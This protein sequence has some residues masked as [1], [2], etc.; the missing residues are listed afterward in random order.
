MFKPINITASAKSINES[1][2]SDIIFDQELQY[3]CNQLYQEAVFSGA[4]ETVKPIED[5][6]A[7]I[8]QQ[9]ETEIERHKA[10]VKEKSSSKLFDP[11]AF[12]KNL[13]FKQ[14]EDTIQKTFGFRT[15]EIEP[16]IE[17]YNSSSDTFESNECNACVW[18]KNR[19][20]IDGLVTDKG[21]YDKTHSINCA[22]LFTLGMLRMYTAGELTAA[23][24]HEIG[25]DIDPALVNI[26]YTD[27]NALSKYLTNR[28]GNLS[29]AEQDAINKKNGIFQKIVSCMAKLKLITPSFQGIKQFISSILPDKQMKE[30]HSLFGFGDATPRSTQKNIDKITAVIVQNTKDDFNM[31]TYSEAF[32]D[33]F[34]RM[35]G[36]GPECAS[37]LK[38]MS[39]EFESRVNSRFKKEKDRQACIMRMVQSAMTDV[40]KTDVH[41]VKAL[42][43]EYYKDINDPNIPAEVK[44]Q[45]KDDVT[46]LEKVLDA[47]TN[48][49]SDFQ[50]R[51]NKIIIAE[52]DKQHKKSQSVNE[53]VEEFDESKQ[54]EAKM[55][56]QLHAVTQAERN[57]FNKLFGNP[58]CSLAK[59]KDGYYCRTHR[60]RSKSYPAIKDIPK[61]KV[62]FVNSTC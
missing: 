59:D 39:K 56:K 38:K 42:I 13:K 62:E 61:E 6:F 24:L 34:A 5:A 43:N 33:N 8:K 9:L 1:F 31:Q 51:I 50:N 16:L 19:Y 54:A 3:G 7:D 23:I 35:Y 2:D 55:K 57:E 22:I 46:E 49:F 40:H 30:K 17:K 12:W 53:S 25:H 14:L 45:L 10:G 58:G 36:Y 18:T 44:K 28:K 20:P 15:V 41:R 21:F 11:K 27:V 4:R 37:L 26:T 52:I 47:F 60:C 32:A 29:K 48:D